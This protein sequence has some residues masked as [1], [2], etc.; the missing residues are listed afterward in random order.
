MKAAADERSP[1]RGID[2]HSRRTNRLARYIILQNGV[3]PL[4]HVTDRPSQLASIPGY[5]EMIVSNARESV[6]DW[7]FLNLFLALSN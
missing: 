1:A 2:P 7:R 5:R 4:V 6:H 3:V